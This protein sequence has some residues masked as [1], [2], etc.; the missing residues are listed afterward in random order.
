MTEREYQE[1]LRCLTDPMDLASWRSWL[2]GKRKVYLSLAYDG[3]PEE[4]RVKAEYI[5]SQI[6]TPGY[7]FVA[8]YICLLPQCDSAGKDLEFAKEFALRMVDECD[9]FWMVRDMLSP[10]MVDEIRRAVKRGKKMRSVF[11]TKEA[12]EDE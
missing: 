10:N 4:Y 8:P 11:P 1:R 2:A 3:D 12:D 5:A 9:E 6:L 7:V